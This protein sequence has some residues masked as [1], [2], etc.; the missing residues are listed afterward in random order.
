ME[1]FF[2]CRKASKGRPLQAAASGCPPPAVV[3]GVMEA[4]VAVKVPEVGANVVV[5]SLAVKSS[6][7][8]KLSPRATAGDSGQLGHMGERN[9]PKNC[10]SSLALTFSGADGVKVR[11]AAPVVHTHGVALT[12]AARVEGAAATRT[13]L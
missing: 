9:K 12:F 5:V 3:G 2:S 4:V 1:P 8:A 6:S 13:R 11:A 7:S 10:V